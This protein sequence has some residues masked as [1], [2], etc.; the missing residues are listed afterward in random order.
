MKL[1]I[2]IHVIDFPGWKTILTEQLSKIDDS[3][4]G[5]EAAEINFC[6]NGSLSNFNEWLST[7][8][9][10]KNA[11]FVHVWTSYNL[12]EYPT[13]DYIKRQCDTAS[14]DSAVLYLHPKGISKV[15]GKDKMEDWRNYM[16]YWVIEQYKDCIDKLSTHDAVGVNYR[17][18]PW[19]H[20]SG[21]MWWANAAYIK[22]LPKQLHPDI[23]HA[24]GYK[25]FRPKVHCKWTEDPRFDCE[26]W[27]GTGVYLTNAKLYEIYSSPLTNP[28]SGWH[29][30]NLWPR[31]K[32]EKKKL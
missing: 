25:Q 3:G 7:Q 9:G 4:L 5:S 13:L 32:Y 17:T 26:S 2:Y 18:H 11:K 15:D 31:S 20:F 8:A 6:L 24:R 27:I 21:N 16:E 19:P 22:K 29:Y 28:T 23:L 30:F 10:R 14:D 1:K 12:Y